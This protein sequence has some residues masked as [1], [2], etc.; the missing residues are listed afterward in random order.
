MCFCLYVSFMWSLH[1]AHTI[2]CHPPSIYSLANVGGL[3]TAGDPGI[4]LPKESLWEIPTNNADHV[5]SSVGL[6]QKLALLKELYDQGDALFVTNSGLLQF[7]V[8][9]DDYRDTNV[10]LFAHNEMERE[11]NREDLE[12][13][14]LGTGVL[15][16]MRDKISGAGFSCNAYSIAG[17]RISLVGMPGVTDAPIT[18][19]PDGMEKLMP[20]YEASW[21]TDG[22]LTPDLKP[23]IL[24]LNNATTIDSPFMAE[25]WSAKVSNAIYQHDE[26]YNALKETTVT[27]T[28]KDSSGSKSKLC[29]QL[30][31]TAKV[32]ATRETRGAERDLFHVQIGG[33]DHHSKVIEKLDIDFE[34]VNLCL[35]AFVEEIKNMGLWD[36]TAL[37]QFSGTVP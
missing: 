18:L 32:M 37:I 21:W 26:L 31:M 29:R 17:S 11:T 1:T 4:A 7:P 22:D 25:T 33:F 3:S 19:S 20:Q 15:G 16:R 10:Q 34:D 5:C 9:K 23:Y 30:E 14:K 13:E 12:D 24:S 8:T 28:F 2:A 36:D 27:A 35:S 6:H